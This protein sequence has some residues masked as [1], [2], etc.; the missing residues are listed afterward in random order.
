[1][2][3]TFQSGLFRQ[4]TDAA[5]VITTA[6]KVRFDVY[7]TPFGLFLHRSAREPGK[8]GEPADFVD[9]DERKLMA[10]VPILRDPPAG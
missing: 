7:Q 5:Q 2:S 4:F 6:G 1:V 10:N 3:L 9:F 8:A